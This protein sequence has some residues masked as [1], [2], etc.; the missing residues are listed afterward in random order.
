MAG[1][2]KENLLKQ[3]IKSFCLMKSMTANKKKAKTKDP[4][5]G[6]GGWERWGDFL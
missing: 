3:S 2:C 4:Q 1:W 5:P 6:A